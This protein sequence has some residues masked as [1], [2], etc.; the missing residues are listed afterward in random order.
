MAILENQHPNPSK[1]A[2][3]C[4]DGEVRR[5]RN[6]E[7]TIG[8]PTPKTPN[9]CNPS[10]SQGGSSE[11]SLPRIQLSM[12][13]VKRKNLVQRGTFEIGETPE[14][15]R[16]KA[17]WRGSCPSKMALRGLTFVGVGHVFSKIPWTMA[18]AGL[19]SHAMRMLL[20]YY[21]TNYPHKVM[22]KVLS[23]FKSYQTTL[24]WAQAIIEEYLSNE[25]A[26]K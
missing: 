9:R 25:L 11:I 26:I 7:G 18:F 15:L 17:I 8:S 4:N 14:T 10:I 16:A 1:Q 22:H 12:L 20:D 3:Q 6:L 2:L 21:T 19:N 24:F 23:Y 5:G 13:T